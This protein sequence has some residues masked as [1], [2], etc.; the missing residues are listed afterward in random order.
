MEAWVSHA[1]ATGDKKPQ[2]HVPLCLQQLPCTRIVMDG[3]RMNQHLEDLCE[4]VLQ[5]RMTRSSLKL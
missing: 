4:P 3:K 2:K 1:K 5:H